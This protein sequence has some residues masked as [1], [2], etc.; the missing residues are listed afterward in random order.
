MSNAEIADSFLQM[1]EL[2]ARDFELVC[3]PLVRDGKRAHRRLWDLIR[4][5]NVNSG[6]RA[7]RR[8]PMG[9]VC[10]GR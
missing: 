6:Y 2:A 8:S 5:G 7:P 4:L 9:I 1:R 3:R 10:G